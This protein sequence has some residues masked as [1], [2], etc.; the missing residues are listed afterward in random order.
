MIIRMLGGLFVPSAEAESVEI[1]GWTKAGAVEPQGWAK[2]G[3]VG[4]QGGSP[5]KKKEIEIVRAIPIF[6]SRR[7]KQF[8]FLGYRAQSQFCR[9][10]LRNGGI[11]SLP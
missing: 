11:H 6:M 9:S 7:I 4:I 3:A 8:L 10:K 2:A 1:Q 5:D